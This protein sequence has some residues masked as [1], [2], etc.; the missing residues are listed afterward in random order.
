D[1]SDVGMDAPSL[2]LVMNHLG[3]FGEQYAAGFLNAV[4]EPTSALAISGLAALAA[5]GRRR[6]RSA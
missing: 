6:R 1:R 4:P 5:S 2:Q 3:Q